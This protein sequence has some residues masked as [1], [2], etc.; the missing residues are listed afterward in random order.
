[1]L[2]FITD[3]FKSDKKQRNEDLTQ[4]LLDIIDNAQA[5]ERLESL[6]AKDEY[7]CTTEEKDMLKVICQLFS[8]R[9]VIRSNDIPVSFSL[10][11]NTY[12]ELAEELK[13]LDRMDINKE[14]EEI[15]Q[16]VTNLVETYKA[17][18]HKRKTAKV[19]E[20]VEVL[21]ADIFDQQQRE[22]LRDEIKAAIF[23]YITIMQD[24]FTSKTSNL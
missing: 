5:N 4:E 12:N 14:I 19:E 9:L 23:L 13:E 6:L 16:K 8:Y 11:E 3:I 2:E 18:D 22:K 7:N 21:I 17:C 15:K 1:M 24:F 20:A 10:L